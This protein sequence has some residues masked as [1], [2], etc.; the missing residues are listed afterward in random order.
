MMDLVHTFGLGCGIGWLLG[1]GALIYGLCRVS[2]RC[3]RAE[4]AQPMPIPEPDREPDPQEPHD[5]SAAFGE[6]VMQ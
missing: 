1:A 4:E 2:G 3:S 6:Q 5:Y